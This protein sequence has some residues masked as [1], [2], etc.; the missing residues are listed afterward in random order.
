MTTKIKT[1]KYAGAKFST[2]ADER[3]KMIEEG[4]SVLDANLL[5]KDTYSGSILIGTTVSGNIVYE[6][7]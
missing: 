7:K 6:K 5:Q 1:I 4:W 2:Y 3:S